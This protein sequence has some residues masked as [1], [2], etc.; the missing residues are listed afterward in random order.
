MEQLRR[1]AAIRQQLR[2]QDPE[3]LQHFDTVMEQYDRNFSMRLYVHET[4]FRET[5]WSQG[6]DEQYA[7]YRDAIDKMAVIGCFAMTEM[8]Y[9]SYLR[10]LET[11][12]TFDTKTQEFIINTYV[13]VSV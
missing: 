11:T 1:A 10:G 7:Q 13:L 4:L 6:T 8:G 2:T 12:A 5:I 3:L 9:S